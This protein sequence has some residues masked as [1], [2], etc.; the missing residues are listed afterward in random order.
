MVPPYGKLAKQTILLQKEY[1]LA[2]DEFLTT[3]VEM[4]KKFYGKHYFD[5]IRFCN[6]VFDERNRVNKVKAD[7]EKH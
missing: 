7:S 6:A 4:Y 1:G 3:Q 5:E 2:I